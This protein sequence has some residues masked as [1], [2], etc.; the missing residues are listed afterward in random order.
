MAVLGA[1]SS[2][3]GGPEGDCQTGALADRRVR[4]FWQCYDRRLSISSRRSLAGALARLDGSSAPTNHTRLESNRCLTGAVR[5]RGAV[6]IGGAVRSFHSSLRRYVATSLRCNSRRV[7]S[8]NRFLTGAVRLRGAVRLKGAVRTRGAVRFGG[9]VR[10]VGIPQFS[11]A[12][13]FLAS[14]PAT[15]YC[16]KVKAC[17][18]KQAVRAIVFRELGGC[19]PERFVAWPRSECYR[20]D[21]FKCSCGFRR[22]LMGGA[23]CRVASSVFW[24]GWRS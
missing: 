21:R 4:C 17:R 6:R 23:S 24:G 14:D 2:G 16:A 18:R 11:S 1:A 22:R 13:F 5:L 10:N 19:A 3:L 20:T 12:R 8:L 7:R 9:T 15:G